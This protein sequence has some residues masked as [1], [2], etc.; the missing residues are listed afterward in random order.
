MA[1]AVGD[2][3]GGTETAGTFTAAAISGLGAS[4]LQADMLSALKE[5]AGN[6]AALVDEVAA[7]GLQ[8]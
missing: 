2:V 8:P 7:G 3:G 4:S 5:V 1:Q 6:T